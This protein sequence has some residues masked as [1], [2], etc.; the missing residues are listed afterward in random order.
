[1]FDVMSDDG[2]LLSVEAMTM[3]RPARMTHVVT[4]A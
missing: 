1:M 2:L 3:M 4:A